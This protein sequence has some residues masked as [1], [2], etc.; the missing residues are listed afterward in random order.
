MKWRKLSIRVSDYH[1]TWICF[2]TKWRFSGSIITIIIAWFFFPEPKAST[3]IRFELILI[4][5]KTIQ[6]L[7]PRYFSSVEWRAKATKCK[8]CSRCNYEDPEFF[9]LFESG[10]IPDHNLA[11]FIC[12]SNFNSISV[13]WCSSTI[14]FHINHELRSPQSQVDCF[15]GSFILG[16]FLVLNTFL[17]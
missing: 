3:D 1:F 10:Y 6:N 7:K 8:N 5:L 14:G 11:L 9:S 13:F 2:L 4:L 12:G 16:K 15:C 17:I